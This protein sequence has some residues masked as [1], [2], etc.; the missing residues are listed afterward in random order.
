MDRW[1]YAKDEHPPYCTC[2][3]CVDAKDRGKASRTRTFRRSFGNL[4]ERITSRLR[5]F[6][7]R[8]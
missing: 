8:L 5:R 2:V 7:T 4:F 6:F 1:Q 3:K